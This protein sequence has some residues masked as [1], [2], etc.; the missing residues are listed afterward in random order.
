[1]SEAGSNP[2]R[3]ATHRL[4]YLSVFFFGALLV[5]AAWSPLDVSTQAQGVV[6]PSSRIKAVQHLEGGIVQAILVREGEQVRRNQPLLR[7]DPVSTTADLDELKRRLAGLAAEIGRLVAEVE[8]RDEPE[9]P[10]E[11]SRADPGLVQTERATFLARRQR[12]QH[13]WQTLKSLITQREQEQVENRTRQE[14][15]RKILATVG[16]QVEISKKMM[17][18]NLTSRMTHLDLV[19]QKQAVEGQIASDKAAAPRIEASLREARERA[20]SLRANF[21]ETARK[22]L[23]QARQS[24]DELAQRLRKL[25]H[26]SELTVVRSPVD[27]IV[28]SMAIATEG[29][30]IQPG[31]T[32]MEIVPIEDQLVIDAR[33]PVQ[34]VGHV[35]AGQAVWVSLNAQDAV[36]FGRI[37]GR[38]ESIS[39]DALVTTEGAT[40]YRIRIVTEKNRFERR[41]RHYSLYPG[42][43]VVCQILIGG[44]TVLEYLVTPWLGSF[45][46]TFQER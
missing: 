8:G 7:L 4:F 27:G 16:D 3:R 21:T 37:E 23:S 24:H 13:E 40:Y 18:R 12:F 19:R 44:R 41:E 5:W 38:V 9:F 28:K 43:Q 26:T 17:E 34:E 14:N 29:G 11:V 30:V 36:L 46:A 6:M 20:E 15:N 42:V 1:M 10:P 25:E 33:L 32:V 22:E 35:R 45:H 31:Q 2:G 39:P